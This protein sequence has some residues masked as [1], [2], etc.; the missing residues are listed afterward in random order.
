MAKGSEQRRPLPHRRHALGSRLRLDSDTRRSTSVSL[1]TAAA[2]APA[3]PLNDVEPPTDRL[4]RPTVMPACAVAATGAANGSNTAA[5]AGAGA[6]LPQGSNDAAARPGAGAGASNRPAMSA[7]LKA[8][9][10]AGAGAGAAGR[11]AAAGAGAG[12]GAGAGCEAVANGSK[13]PPPLRP[14]AAGAGAGAAMVAPDRMDTCA[15]RVDGGTSGCTRNPSP[16][17]SPPRLA[18][19]CAHLQPTSRRTAGWLGGGRGRR[20]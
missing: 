4:P 6:G 2:G 11:R 12:T 7:P 10:G 5:A 20:R 19:F 3:P 14:T 1:L 13:S 8:D 9:A 17:P 18:R 15:R 16:P